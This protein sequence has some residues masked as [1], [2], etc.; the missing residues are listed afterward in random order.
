VSP[1]SFYGTAITTVRMIDFI[2][3]FVKT[4]FFGFGIALVGCFE[5]LNCDYGTK[6]VGHA[7]TKAVVNVSLFIVFA[8]FFLTRLFVIVL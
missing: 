8:D 1:Q 4:V 6:G 7:T 3:G 2:S 5:G